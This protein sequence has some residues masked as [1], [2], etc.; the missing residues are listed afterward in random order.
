VLTRPGSFPAAGPAANGASPATFVD[1]GRGLTD[2]L[3]DMERELITGAMTVAG[4]NI[5]EAARL[6]KTDRGNLYRRMRRLGI[7]GGGE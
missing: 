6:L 3:D 1:S 7:R 5:A 4:G 2:R